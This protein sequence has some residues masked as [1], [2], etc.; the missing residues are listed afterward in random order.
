MF[1]FSVYLSFCYLIQVKEVAPTE[2][3]ELAKADFTV[4]ADD[5]RDALAE[6]HEGNKNYKSIDIYSDELV[7]LV[8]CL[9]NYTQ[10]RQLFIEL[11]LYFR[12]VHY[13]WTLGILHLISQFTLP[14]KTKME[15]RCFPAYIWNLRS[16]LI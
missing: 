5:V 3:E 13:N 16:H 12:L 4:I 14:F 15:K 1:I 8:S 9:Y 6:N 2:E 7:S 10:W 11:D